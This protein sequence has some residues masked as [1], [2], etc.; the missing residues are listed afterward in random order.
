MEFSFKNDGILALKCYG[1]RIKIVDRKKRF[2]GKFKILK[3]FDYKYDIDEYLT[4]RN[5]SNNYDIVKV[6][7]FETLVYDREWF[8]EETEEIELLDLKWTKRKM[9]DAIENKI[10][11][12]VKAVNK[13]KESGE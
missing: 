5:R 12:L 3:T 1:I 8:D 2:N 7:E 10:N 9:D 6:Y 4:F 13:T 11:E